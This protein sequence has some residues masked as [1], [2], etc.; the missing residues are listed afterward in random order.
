MRLNQLL[1]NKYLLKFLKKITLNKCIY[2][3]Y[4]FKYC[5]KEINDTFF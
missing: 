1:T 2:L 4:L 5:R 3:V